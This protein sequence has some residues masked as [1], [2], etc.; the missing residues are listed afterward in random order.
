MSDGDGETERVAYLCLDFGLPGPGSATV[1]AA[2]VGQEQKPGRTAVAA[3]SF[4]I[5]PSGDGVGGEGRSVVGDADANGTAVVGR[6]VNA[7]RDTYPAGIGKEVV[8]V[9]QNG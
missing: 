4:A 2:G 3:G 7:V 6:V 8:I 1:A 5:P 9:D